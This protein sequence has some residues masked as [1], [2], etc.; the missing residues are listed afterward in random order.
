MSA[1]KA[2][3]SLKKLTKRSPFQ[4]KVMGMY[5]Q[6]VRLSKNQP[7]LLEKARNEFRAASH[8]T[9]KEDSLLIDSKMRRAKN[10]LEMLKTSRV[11]SVKVFSIKRPDSTS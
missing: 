4:L 1:R 10:Q 2:A 3:S 6:Y 11:N 7:G 8:L 9:F 5:A